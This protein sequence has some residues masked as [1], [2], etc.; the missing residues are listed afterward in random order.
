MVN[1]HRLENVA[2]EY[3]KNQTIS[4][5]LKIAGMVIE[6]VLVLILGYEVHKITS[7]DQPK[8]VWLFVEFFSVLSLCALIW[9]MKCCCLNKFCINCCINRI[10]G[11]QSEDGNPT[12]AEPQE[13]VSTWKCIVRKL[14]MILNRLAVGAIGY[15][16][17]KRIFA[18]KPMNNWDYAE[19]AAVALFCIWIFTI[20]YCILKCYAFKCCANCL[21]GCCCF[22]KKNNTQ[23]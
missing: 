11:K 9:V 22:G 16:V 12:D 2:Q 8:D 15:E 18:K 14:H 17:R 21:K 3:V 1:E 20:K 13:K 7:S 6:Y 23:A 5:A 4:L 19:V 10:K